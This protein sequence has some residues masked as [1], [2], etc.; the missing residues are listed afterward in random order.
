[1][2]LSP[3]ASERC[4]HAIVVYKHSGRAYQA[5]IDTCFS[6]SG[7]SSEQFCGIQE[8]LTRPIDTSRQGDR[9]LG[10]SQNGA[11]RD[12]TCPTQRG[13]SGS[14]DSS[15]QHMVPCRFATSAAA[16]LAQPSLCGTSVQPS[17]WPSSS[18]SEGTGYDAPATVSTY[19][20]IRGPE[21]ACVCCRLT[22]T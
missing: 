17:W 2:P 22:R 14:Q 20:R 18:S 6:H 3:K 12:G 8:A 1:M 13:S 19:S 9:G 11:L 16:T 10:D 15:E 5:H 4:A 21:A 7:C